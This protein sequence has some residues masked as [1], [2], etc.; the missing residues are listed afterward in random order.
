MQRGLRHLG[1]I[2]QLNHLKAPHYDLLVKGSGSFIADEK[3]NLTPFFLSQ[4][5]SC[6]TPDKAL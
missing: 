4:S 6:G 1:E 2:A 5:V 3:M